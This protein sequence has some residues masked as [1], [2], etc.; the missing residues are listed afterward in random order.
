MWIFFLLLFDSSKYPDLVSKPWIL[1]RIILFRIGNTAIGI[2]LV[3]QVFDVIKWLL[4]ADLSRPE[5]VPLCWDSG[6]QRSRVA[7][8]VRVV[9]TLFLGS[10]KAIFGQ[11]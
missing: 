1:I 2:D 7:H 9:T 4:S 8:Q 3:C 11:D 5:E 6:L 10:A